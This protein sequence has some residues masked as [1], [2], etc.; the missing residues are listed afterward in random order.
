MYTNFTSNYPGVDKEQGFPPPRSLQLESRNDR[1]YISVRNT[2]DISC[3]CSA[4][5]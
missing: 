2:T 5:F 1:K 3:S 4:S